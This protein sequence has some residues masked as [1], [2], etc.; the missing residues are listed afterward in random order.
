MHQGFKPQLAIAS[1]AKKGIIMNARSL[2]LKIALGVIVV[3]GFAACNQAP[4]LETLDFGD[5]ALSDTGQVVAK[6][7]GLPLEDVVVQPIPDVDVPVKWVFPS[8]FPKACDSSANIVQNPKF[9]AGLANSGFPGNNIP[10][11]T[12][13][14]WQQANGTPQLSPVTA[15]IGAMGH[16][17]PGYVQM[18]GYRSGGEAV[19]QIGLSMSG[20]Y[21]V[22]FSVKQI[23]T[24]N[25]PTPLDVRLVA[26]IGTIPSPW[27][28]PSGSAVLNIPASS[29]AWT[30]YGPLPLNI[31]GTADT[32]TLAS[33]NAIPGA[34]QFSWG[35]YDNVCI[36]PKERLPFDLEIKKDLK[37]KPAVAGAASS[38]TLTVT[39]LGPG[40]SS[41]PIVVA[42]SLPSGL[43]LMGTPTATPASAGF[44][45]ASFAGPT[46]VCTSTTPM[47]AGS[48][49]QIT[50]PVIVTQTAGTVKNCARVTAAGDATFA[51]SNPQNNDSCVTTDVVPGRPIDLSITKQLLGSSILTTGGTGT[52]QLAVQNLGGAIAAGPVTV[53][54]PMP[55]GLTLLTASITATPTSDWNCAAST[56]AQLSCNYSGAFPIATGYIGNLQ[57]DVSVSKKQLGAV[58]NCARVSLATDPALGNNASCIK[59]P[60]KNPLISDPFELALTDALTQLEAY[61]ETAPDEAEAMLRVTSGL[62]DTLKTQ[63]RLVQG[64]TVE[65]LAA[66]PNS[67]TAIFQGEAGTQPSQIGIHVECHI[68]NPPLKAGCSITWID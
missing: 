29:T 28:P 18:W 24:S 62:K 23:N 16:G 58:K 42:D 4:T 20:A 3:V 37:T 57:F 46:V 45:C 15:G 2:V 59:N 39:N 40:L 1:T 51:D 55:T 50:I 19:R 7:P 13:A 63:V 6:I 14:N 35:Q 49:V 26:S 64:L 21:D 38:Y 36:L 65:P 60:V 68:T 52:Y 54:D 17:N 56:T 25:N 48:S 32:I 27:T 66:S 9:M 5:V 41:Q 67:F 53:T 8:S 47:P 34:S 11:A 61:T 33:A 44:S 10:P 31:V 30:M 12:V 22:Y 43:S